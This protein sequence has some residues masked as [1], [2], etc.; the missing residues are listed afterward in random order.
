MLKDG[1]RFFYNGV[2]SAVIN[3]RFL[4]NYFNISRGVRQGCPLSPLLSIL[5]AELLAVKIRQ[6]PTCRG[7]AL[8]DD[9][10]VKI[11]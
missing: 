7:F 10:V 1:L 8:P 4:T 9:Q 5:A 2:Q 11:S 3:G 6:E